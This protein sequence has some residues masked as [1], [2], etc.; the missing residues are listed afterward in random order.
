MVQHIVER[1]RNQ[2]LVLSLY[3]LECAHGVGFACACLPVHKQRAVVSIQH[4]VYYLEPSRVE[5]LLLGSGF[6]E[7]LIKIEL[8]Y[9][10][11]LV[12][13]CDSTVN[14]FE[15]LFGELVP[16]GTNPDVDVYLIVLIIFTIIRAL[17]QH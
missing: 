12:V 14:N 2:T 11:I 13:K 6:I 9:F 8:M 4:V 15:G 5:D 17:L 3:R 16:H 7:D 1:Q 10:V